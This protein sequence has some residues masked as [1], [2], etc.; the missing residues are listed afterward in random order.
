M[1]T[2]PNEVHNKPKLVTVFGGSGFVGRAVVAS[3]TKRGYRVRVAVRKPDAAYYMAPL[4]N[5][6]QIQMLQAN[7]RNRASVERAIIGA[8]HVINLVG[9]LSES[10][11][12]RF[13]AV[14]VLGAKN[15]AEAT[16]AAGLKLT[17]L[18]SLAADANS[19]SDYARTKAEGEK[20]IL[21]VL[22]DTV[23]LRP[24]IIFGHEDRFFNRFANMARFSPFLPVIGG[25]ETKLQPVY[26]GDVAEAVARA[27]DGKLTAGTVY[28]LGGPDVQPFKHW[29]KDMLGVIARKRI[30]VSMPFWIA[31]I[32]ASVLGLLPNPLLTN[33]Q[34][35]LL[36]S[37]NVVSDQAA[38][39]GRTLQ[40][41]GIKPE[42]VDAILPAY[43]WRYRVAGQYTK[44]GFA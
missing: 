35:T 5:V 33:D 30:I 34:V 31:R 40:G 39:E 2:E 6:G 12:Q 14:Q 11:K 19:A 32:Q 37:D 8:D 29:M 42:T 24:S 3:L 16:K 36:K 18:S 44:T 27:V 38:K 10:G 43:L 7:V 41:I 9:I 4:G 1:K 20:A 15:I 22:P 25:G 26:V 23:I 17:H 13:N 28:E 21:S